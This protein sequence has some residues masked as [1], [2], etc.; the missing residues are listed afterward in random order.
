MNKNLKYI[1]EN[2][3]ELEDL[4]K[5][6]N[7]TKQQLQTLTDN[8]LIP[9]PSYEI[10]NN[11]TISSP[12][13]DKET[14]S[15]THKYYHKSII[16]LIAKNKGLKNSKDYKKNLKAEFL[17]T[18]INSKDNKYGYDNLLNED[19]KV[20]I[21]KLNIVFEQEWIHYLNGIYGICTLNATGSEIAKKEIAVKKLINFNQKHESLI[22]SDEDKGILESL[23][24]QFN[25][26]SSLF[27][28]YQRE[29][30]S[31]GKYLDRILKHNSLSALVQKYLY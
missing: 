18:F 30:S 24:T 10:T 17:E 5:A 6:T 25:E 26:V 22:L 15:E 3:I 12:L 28:P 8:E 21:D 23:N 27:A 13:G 7:I 4:C 9:K 14:I 31:R 1:K 11:Y 16:D 29:S 2:F 20:D 19:G